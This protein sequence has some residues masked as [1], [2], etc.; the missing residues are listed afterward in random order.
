MNTN[1]SNSPHAIY[2]QNNFSPKANIQ[3]I[4]GRKEESQVIQNGARQVDSDVPFVIPYSS[5]VAA[6]AVASPSA[7]SICP[8]LFEKGLNASH[9]YRFWIEAEAEGCALRL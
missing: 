9:P 5:S 8:T 3:S 4:N 2:L 1:Q 6:V 7:Y